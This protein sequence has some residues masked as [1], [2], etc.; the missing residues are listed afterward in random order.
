MVTR[1]IE[2]INTVKH[3]YI[4]QRESSQYLEPLLYFDGSTEQLGPS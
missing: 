2:A 1:N 4:T 3:P